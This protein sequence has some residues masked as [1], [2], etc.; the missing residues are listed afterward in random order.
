MP[1]LFWLNF[2]IKPKRGSTIQ[3][4]SQKNLLKKYE[5]KNFYIFNIFDNVLEPS[6]EIW[7]F[8]SF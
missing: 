8:V 7:C 1:C 4:F 2:A 6:I 3:R 5:G